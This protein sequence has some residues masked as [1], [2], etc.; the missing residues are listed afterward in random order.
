MSFIN[1]VKDIFTVSGSRFVL[2]LP[3]E[4]HFNGFVEI[5]SV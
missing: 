5:K 4:G 2:H 3:Y 1:P